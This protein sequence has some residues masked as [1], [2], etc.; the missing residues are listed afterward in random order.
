[1]AF[2][3]PVDMP[4]DLGLRMDRTTLVFALGGVDGHR[5]GLRSR[6]GAAGIE[7]PDDQ[8]AEGR[9]PQR[10][11]RPHD[12]PPAQRAGRR[13]GR[14][15]PGAAGRRDAVP[16][17]LHRGAIAVAG[18]RRLAR[19]HRIDGHVPQR[20]HR[21]S[22]SRIPAPRHRSGVGHSGRAVGRIRIAPA[23]RIRRQQLDQRR[24]R[25]LRAARE[26]GDR[27]QLQH[28]RARTTSRRWASRSGRAANT[29]T[30]TRC[31]RRGRS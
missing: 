31:S 30:P 13:A 17:Q 20:L 18:F 7:Q 12:R 19:R 24:R 25:R 11:R 6:A 29:T 16:P 22:A 4:I 9:R 2:V 3:P 26:R 23:A 10:Q 15:V 28:D 21:R 14:R 1:M 5:A 27:H 8:R